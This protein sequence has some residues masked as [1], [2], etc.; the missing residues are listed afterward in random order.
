MNNLAHP[1]VI[2]IKDV[3][4]T[5]SYLVLVLEL[6]NGGDFQQL[7]DAN[8]RLSER[9]AR[10][11]FH[12]IVTALSY[13]HA[14]KIVHRDLKPENILVKNPAGR[15]SPKLVLVD[16]GLAKALGDQAMTTTVCGTPLYIAPEVLGRGVA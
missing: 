4:N 14:R 16:F 1:N 12:Q 13:L 11:C 3:F 5:P 9:A 15:A 10:I 7:I 6:C 2:D 8:R